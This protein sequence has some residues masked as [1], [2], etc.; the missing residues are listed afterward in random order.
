MRQQAIVL[1]LAIGLLVTLTQVSLASNKT[2]KNEDRL[3]AVSKQFINK[4]FPTDKISYVIVDIDGL[5]TTYEV[6][7]TT[8]KEIEF[9]K[10]GDWKEIDGKKQAIPVAIIPANIVKHVKDNFDDN[11]FIVQ[12]ERKFWGIEVEL[13]NKLDIDF[14]PK[15]KFIRYDN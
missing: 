11:V 12:I 9:Y 14:S 7:L 6:M 1:I 8:G 5:R 3:P 10:N 4:H 2:S 13:S 15:G